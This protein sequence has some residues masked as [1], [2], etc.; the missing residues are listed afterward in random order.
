MD[1]D[2][3]D[4][5]PPL[6]ADHSDD[7]SDDS[8]VDYV[9]NSQSSSDDE[10]ACAKSDHV[11]DVGANANSDINHG[12]N[13]QI[14]AHGNNIKVVG[15]SN[16]HKR[17]NPHQ[18][19]SRKAMKKQM[20]RQKRS[21]NH[22]HAKKMQCCDIHEIKKFVHNPP[23]CCAQNC[24]TKFAAFKQRAITAVSELRH[25]RFARKLQDSWSTPLTLNW[26]S[27]PRGG[28]LVASSQK[29]MAVCE[30]RWIETK[31]LIFYLCATM[32]QAATELVKPN[33]LRPM[34]KTLPRWL[35]VNESRNSITGCHYLAIVVEVH[36]FSASACQIRKMQGYKVLKHG[37]VGQQMQAP[38]LRNKMCRI[39]HLTH[40]Q[41]F[42]KLFCSNIFCCIRRKVLLQ[43]TCKYFCV[44]LVINIACNDTC[45]S[46]TFANTCI[47]NRYVEFHGMQALY[48]EYEAD[49]DRAGVQPVKSSYF[50]KLWREV[51]N[52]GVI[53]PETGQ[54]YNTHVRKNRARGF[55]R[56]D[57]CVELNAK[58]S[59]SLTRIESEAYLNQLRAHHAEVKND[60]FELARIAR[61]CKIDP[62][63]VGFMID[64]VDKN[65]F[66][67]PTTERQSKS[68]LAKLTKRR[69]I[70]KI[71]GV[72]WFHDD[73]IHLFKSL[74]DVPTGG[75]LTLTILTELF[76][77]PRVQSAT[78][79]YINFDGAS[80]NVCYH[81]IYGVAHLL[82]SANLAGWPL[83]RV[84]LLRFK[85][86]HTH[87]QLDGTFGLLTRNIYGRQ[88]GGTTARD[89]L[90]F[91]GFKKVCVLCVLCVCVR[92]CVCVCCVC[93]VC[94][95]VCVCALCVRVC[96]RCVCV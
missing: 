47:Q 38:K 15:A 7:D 54:Y 29:N 76:K 19:K 33:G 95:R 3:C 88:C 70:Q 40:V 77:T 67:L 96:V 82:R 23:G 6:V 78:D 36:G 53:D 72:Q 27:T 17:K 69:I 50:Y 13:T 59:A 11:Q 18:N 94:V 20:S 71:T 92:A 35:V 73:S 57:H 2:A 28:K 34:L 90:S 12:K 5:L 84:H 39:K 58:I 24:L 68:L 31:M 91:I 1:E 21:R 60:R 37:F 63:H 65:K 41:I 9:P 61:L 93:V 80:D 22:T 49:A 89:M 79:L 51:M 26:F 87:N 85:V 81:V 75:N 52:S 32:L 48:A 83:Q 43:R 44:F 42:A 64:A 74:P 8:D 10:D 56:C 45:L 30:Q 55:A 66:G 46:L 16:P 25:N 4:D 62:R 86:G 14:D